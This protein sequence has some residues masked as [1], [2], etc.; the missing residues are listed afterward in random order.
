MRQSVVFSCV[1]LVAAVSVTASAGVSW[2]TFA[3]G[4]AGFN[5]LTVNGAL[6]RSVAEGRIGNNAETGTWEQA[7]WQQGGVGSPVAS[8]QQPAFTS[9]AGRAWSFAWD[10]VN[11]VTYTFGSTSQV[12]SAVAGGFTDIFLR[13][14]ATATS[15][16]ELSNMF[17]D[18]PGVVDDTA[19]GD[20][21]TP[22]SGTASY[23]RISSTMGD[24]PA[25][26]LSGES[27]F[28]WSGAVPTNSSLAY[29]IKFTNVIPSPGVAGLMAVA[30]IAGSRRRRA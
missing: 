7:V 13:V 6:E 15:S 11:T 10:G 20:L 2:S 12:W 30:G 4:D 29:Q 14:R 22:V 17:L 9:G 21:V 24:L 5:A 16:A 23:I 27:T 1:A 18:L 26:T 19:I 3:G 25:F 28:S 8:G